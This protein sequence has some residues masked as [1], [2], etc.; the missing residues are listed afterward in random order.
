[1]WC[2][3]GAYISILFSLCL[4]SVGG[5]FLAAHTAGAP[6]GWDLMLGPL[7]SGAGALFLPNLQRQIL[8]Y[9]TLL[10]AAAALNLIIL[11]R[12][13]RHDV[14]IAAGAAGF[15]GA[16][17]V[18]LAYKVHWATWAFSVQLH[19]GCGSSKALA[20]ARQAFVETGLRDVE[21][22]GSF[23]R[24]GPDVIGW[25]HTSSSARIRTT[26]PLIVVVMGI[27]KAVVSGLGSVRSRAHGRD[28]PFCCA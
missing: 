25:G 1:M 21:Q 15:L 16:A 24:D 27:M 13:T 9:A 19:E 18:V 3:S 12:V 26:C 17:S 8:W 7:G 14:H 6:Q 4:C 28:D 22:A 20:D 2:K 11:V 23:P 10:A 5:L